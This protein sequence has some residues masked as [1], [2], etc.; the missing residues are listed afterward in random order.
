MIVKNVDNIRIN[1]GLYFIAIEVETGSKKNFRR[2]KKRARDLN[3]KCNDWF[4][5]ITSRNLRKEYSKYGKTYVRTELPIKIRS[6]FQK[7]NK[8]FIDEKLNRVFK[9]YGTRI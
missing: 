3:R 2:I 5:V 6:Y 7:T 4:F 8:K 1:I 9:P